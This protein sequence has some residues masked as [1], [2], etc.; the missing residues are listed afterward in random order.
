MKIN[1][2]SYDKYVFHLLRKCQTFP[3]CLYDFTFP[4]VKYETP[5]LSAFLPALGG[6][7]IFHFSLSESCTVVSHHGLGSHFPNG[8]WCWA[9]SL[10][11]FAICTCSSVRPLYVFYL[12]SD[13][14]LLSS[15]SFL[16]ILDN[17]YLLGMLFPNIFPQS[18]ACL[19]IH[20]TGSFAGKGL[21]LLKFN[22]FIV[23]P[24]VSSLL[25]SCL[26]TLHS[27]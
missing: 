14:S 20:L 10:C 9:S 8:Y 24:L 26:R 17:T 7:T 15:E 23:F 16:Y 6:V 22:L 11:L 27:T 5:R 4:P 19:F 21:F 13:C 2:R 12:F 1:T 18:L 25:V 3:K